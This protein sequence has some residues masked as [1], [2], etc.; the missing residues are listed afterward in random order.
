MTWIF[1]RYVC[2]TMYA[3]ALWLKTNCTVPKFVLKFI[4]FTLETCFYSIFLFSA[5]CQEYFELMKITTNG[6]TTASDH[7]MLGRG[8][9]FWQKKFHKIKKVNRVLWFH[10]CTERND[11][12]KSLEKRNLHSRKKLII[13]PS[14]P[15]KVGLKVWLKIMF[16]NTKQNCFIS[17]ATLKEFVNYMNCN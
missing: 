10:V 11:W 12:F 17:Y 14:L 7:S 8:W 6:L 15:K 5:S 4:T 1:V 9:Q 3:L 16:V 2:C 13:C